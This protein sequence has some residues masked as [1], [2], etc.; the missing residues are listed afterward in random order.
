M[1]ECRKPFGRKEVLALCGAGF[2]L[3]VCLAALAVM[4]WRPEVRGDAAL[5]AVSACG[6][7]GAIFSFHQVQRGQTDR[8]EL[9]REPVA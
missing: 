4:A 6:A 7:F 5:V 2:V 3:V 1:D 8:A 9:A